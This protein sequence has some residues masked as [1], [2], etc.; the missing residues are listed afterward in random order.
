MQTADPAISNRSF[1]DE[2][3]ASLRGYLAGG[4]LGGGDTS[5]D[6]LTVDEQA[7]LFEAGVLDSLHLVGMIGF[8]ESEFECSLDYDELTEENLGTLA[9]ILAMIERKRAANS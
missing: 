9:A 2:A 7:N 6:A 4:E 3:I 1:R 5:T 8:I